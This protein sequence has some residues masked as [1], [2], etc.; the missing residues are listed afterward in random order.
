MPRNSGG[1]YT[2]P[3]GTYAVT[4][5]TISSSA[6]DT[7]LSDIS[8]EMTNSVNVQ[9]TAPM[10]APFNA[11]GY[12][13]TNLANGVA[14]TD[15]ATLA[16][17]Q[18][19]IPSGFILHF[20]SSTVPSGFLECNGASVSTTT[21]ANL[22]AVIG[23]TYGGSGGS[24]NV[25]DLRGYFI[26][27]WDHGA[28]RD[29]N[30]ASRTIASTEAAANMTHTHGITDPTHAHAVSDPGHN[31]FINDPGHTHAVTDPGHHHQFNAAVQTVYGGGSGG[32]YNTSGNNNTTTS[33]TGLTID[34]ATTGIYNSAVTTGVT[35]NLH[36]TGV[37][38]NSAGSAE[39]TV[40]NI[41][42]MPC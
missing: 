14:A 21:Y 20:P 2:P 16:Q 12:K 31:H 5:T 3:S 32:A 1:V 29:V 26:R 22:F 39:V 28:G 15:A 17:A 18:A 41:A 25:P 8:T 23:Y 37:T 4:N 24:F 30:T 19:A 33:T 36:N 38:V 7:F 11:G 42:L 6:Y 35:I 9:G 10:L 13:M 34:T 40:L 27:G